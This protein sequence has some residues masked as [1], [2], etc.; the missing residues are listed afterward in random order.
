MLI[1]FLTGYLPWQNLYS[2]NKNERYERIKNMKI[3]T[4]ISVLCQDCPEEFHEYMRYTRSLKFEETPNYDYM[5]NLVSSLAKKKNINLHDDIYDWNVRAVCIE[6][7]PGFFDFDDN[8]NVHP[9]IAQGRFDRAKAHGIEYTLE[10]E[11]SI[12]LEA[13]QFKF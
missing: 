4:P 13:Q 11:N 9:F 5:L 1:Y 3:E 12:M 10:E 8:Q 6:K 2:G 7:H